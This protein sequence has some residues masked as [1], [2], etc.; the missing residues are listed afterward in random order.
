MRLKRKHG[1]EEMEKIPYV[2]AIGSLIYEMVCIRLEIAHAMAI[3][4][5]YTKTL[6]RYH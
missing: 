1:E 4:R 2:I 6:V 5:R 3:V